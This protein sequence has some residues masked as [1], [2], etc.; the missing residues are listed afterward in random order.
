MSAAVEQPPVQWTPGHLVDEVTPPPRATPS[1]WI[2]G[3]APASTAY[4][5]AGFEDDAGQPEGRRTLA[6]GETMAFMPFQ[7]SASCPSRCSRT[8]LQMFSI[9]SPAGAT[10]FCDGEGYCFGSGIGE[11]VEQFCNAN[12]KPEDAELLAIGAYHWGKAQ[13]FRLA[14]STVTGKAEF[15]AVAAE[16]SEAAA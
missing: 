5:I 11:V 7:T 15:V 6:V 4:L 9:P 3:L 1:D 14:I 2:I 16:P 12:G 10:F 13:P 8:E